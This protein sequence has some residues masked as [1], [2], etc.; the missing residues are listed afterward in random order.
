[1]ESIEKSA[2]FEAVDGIASPKLSEVGLQ[3]MSDHGVNPTPARRKSHRL[4]YC[5]KWHTEIFCRAAGS[6]QKTAC[7]SRHRGKG[8]RFLNTPNRENNLRRRFAGPHK[9]RNLPASLVL[10]DREPGFSPGR[11][12]RAN[13]LFGLAPI[14]KRCLTF[15]MESLGFMKRILMPL[16]GGDAGVFHR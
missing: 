2:P 5:S 16:R 8:S 6:S 11:Y 12:G 13:P 3:S 4:P 10:L 14:G 1:M 9:N 15:G 7:V